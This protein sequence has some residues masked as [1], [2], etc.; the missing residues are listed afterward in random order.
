MKFGETLEQERARHA[1]AAALP[2][3]LHALTL[4]VRV[5]NATCQAMLDAQRRANGT[6][7]GG[8]R[9]GGLEK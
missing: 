8:E 5:L 9:S 3:R 1:A 2:G 7:G 6:N 4:K